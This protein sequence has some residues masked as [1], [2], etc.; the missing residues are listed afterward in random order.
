MVFASFLY[1]YKKSDIDS[2][3]SSMFKVL[4]SFKNDFSIDS[5][6]SI[7]E[8]VTKVDDSLFEFMDEFIDYRNTHLI[9]NEQNEEQ[10]KKL[11]KSYGK[12]KKL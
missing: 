7:E 9:L 12:I 8:E 6:K 3:K 11:V 1:R 4:I 2:I 5:F 10:D